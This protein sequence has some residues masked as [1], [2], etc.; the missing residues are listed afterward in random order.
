MKLKLVEAV[1]TLVLI[2]AFLGFAA[3]LM[4]DMA[5]HWMAGC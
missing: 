5:I 3:Y 1:V 2:A 4:W